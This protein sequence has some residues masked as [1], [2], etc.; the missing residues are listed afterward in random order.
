MAQRFL[1]GATVP[2]SIKH[3]VYDDANDAWQETAL[4]TNYPK[5][6]IWDP[7]GTKVVDAQVMSSVGTGRYRYIYSLAA[8]APVGFWK[9]LYEGQYTGE[10]ADVQKPLLSDGFWVD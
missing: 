4:D 10:G 8:A 3:L 2:C 1:Q 5:V 7:A 9:R 6:T